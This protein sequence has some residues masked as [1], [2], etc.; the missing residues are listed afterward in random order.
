[1]SG[2]GQ[3]YVLRKKPPGELL[4]S[5]HMVSIRITSHLMSDSPVQI[6]REF[7][8][9]GRLHGVGF[10][11]PRPHHFCADASIIG[12][13]FYIMQFVE[14]NACMKHRRPPL[15]GRIFRNAQLPGLAPQDRAD[16]YKAVRGVHVGARAGLARRWWTLWRSCMPSTGARRGWRRSTRATTTSS[17][18]LGCC[19]PKRDV[20]LHRWPCGAAS[21]R[22]RRLLVW[23]TGAVT[24]VTLAAPSIPAMDRLVEWLE[25]HVP[26]YNECVIVH[27]DYRI[28]NM[29]FHP[30]EARRSP[31]TWR[32]DT[33]S[34][35]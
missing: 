12:A 32:T 21:T 11:V 19:M 16:I 3:Q 20:R 24:P 15:Q 28:D 35:A 30:T 31:P 18:R 27:G 4:P 25:G 29:V 33:R 1:M 23:R 5:A 26:S 13:P 8:M 7:A 34:R 17:G 10:P 6:E 22:W 14:V 2:R 9:L